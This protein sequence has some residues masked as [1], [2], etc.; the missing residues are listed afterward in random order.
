MNLATLRERG[1][2]VLDPDSGL[3]ACGDEGAGRMPDPPVLADFV[4]QQFAT[5]DLEGRSDPRHRRPDARAD[6]SG[7]LHL[8]SLVGKDGLRASPRPRGEGERT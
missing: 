1:V 5:R 3:L 2:I 4:K 8:Q 7:A 6:R